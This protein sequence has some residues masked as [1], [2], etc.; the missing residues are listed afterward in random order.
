MRID[1]YSRPE[2]EDLTPDEFDAEA[3][4][5]FEVQ[6]EIES[7]GLDYVW[8]HENPDAWK[9]VRDQVGVKEYDRIRRLVADSVTIPVV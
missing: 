5:V 8:A 9:L 1:P 6:G 3:I 4:K 2:E 7:A